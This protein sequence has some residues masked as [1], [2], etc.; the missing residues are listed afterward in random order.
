MQANAKFLGGAGSPM[1]VEREGTVLTPTTRML[2]HAA[3]RSDK[4]QR[5]GEASGDAVAAA[6][7]LL[8]AEDPHA[9]ALGAAVAARLILEEMAASM[10][11]PTNGMLATFIEQ[12]GLAVSSFERAIR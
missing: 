10:Q 5:P 11:H 3:D 1:S 6:V 12:T 9:R 8:A 4:R 2:W 7:D